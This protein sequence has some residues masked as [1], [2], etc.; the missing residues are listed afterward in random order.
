MG[1]EI[2]ISAK[3]PWVFLS[4]ARELSLPLIHRSSHTSP[5]LVPV[6]LGTGADMSPAFQLLSWRPSRPPSSR[7]STPALGRTSPP[8]RC[9]SSRV[10]ESAQPHPCRTRH[11][12]FGRITS[13]CTWTGDPGARLRGLHGASC[14]RP[15]AHLERAC[16]PSQR[17]AGLCNVQI[18]VLLLSSLLSVLDPSRLNACQPRQSLCAACFSRSLRAPLSDRLGEYFGAV[19]GGR[20]MSECCRCCARPLRGHA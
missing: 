10:V 7:S 19:R 4:L 3:K 14:P 16:A 12:V 13:R 15:P 18:V 2:R 8:W 11:A 6:A 9:S 20:N 1:I 5:E 17:T